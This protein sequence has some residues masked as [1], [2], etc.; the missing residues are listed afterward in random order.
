MKPVRSNEG[1]AGLKRE[2]TILQQCRHPNIV[3]IR[4]V[5]VDDDNNVEAM[6]TEFI[7]N[8]ITL[9]DIDYSRFTEQ[10]CD[11]WISQIRS[12]ID[13]LHAHGH[14]WGD[15]KPANI[16]KHPEGHLVLVDFAGDATNGWVT[17]EKMNTKEGDI[18]AFNLIKKFLQQRIAD[19]V[20]SK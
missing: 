6:L 19:V 16:F 15:A 8:A 17:A 4:G 5:V 13:Y 10:E 1:G 9:D 12:A 11:P 20:E 18:Q 14:V 3:P 2:I 7:P